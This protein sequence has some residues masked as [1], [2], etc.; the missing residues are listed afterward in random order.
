LRSIPSKDGAP[1]LPTELT[2][3]RANNVGRPSTVAPFLVFFNFTFMFG[4][5]K[6]SGNIP[7]KK[8][9]NSTCCLILIIFFGYLIYTAL[10]FP[11]PSSNIKIEYMSSSSEEFQKMAR[12][13]LD[14]IKKAIPE[15]DNY[16]CESNDCSSV[17]YFNFKKVPDDL[18]FIMRGNAV[19]FSNFKKNFIGTSYITFIAKLNGVTIL[20]CRGNNGITR[21][22]K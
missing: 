14:D 2:R 11:T 1:C 12:S 9:K 21:E 6:E 20:T 17:I 16:S 19:T 18:D 3:L 8:K 13:R 15:M 5:K 7:L 22:C 4:K 10:H